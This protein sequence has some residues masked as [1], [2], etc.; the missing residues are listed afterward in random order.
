MRMCQKGIITS[1]KF[2][3]VTIPTHLRAALS[4]LN[5]QI[6]S[7]PGKPTHYKKIPLTQG[8]TSYRILS[9]VIYI[10]IYTYIKHKYLLI[11]TKT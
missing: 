7:L 8:V 2:L 6:T 4:F 9:G 3:S 10:Y 5:D 11:V 1:S